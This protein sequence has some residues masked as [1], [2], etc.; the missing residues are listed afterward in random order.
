MSCP[1]QVSC[2]ECRDDAGFTLLE[3][4]VVLAI[5]GLLVGLVAPAAL[6]Q[7]GGARQSVVKQSIARIGTVLDMYKLDTGD[8]P[9]TE[10]GLDA[11]VHR[12][13]SVE[14]WNGPYLKG[15]AV[16]VDPWNHAY[17]YHAPSERE[18]H[19]YDL[20]SHGPNGRGEAGSGMICNP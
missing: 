16:P 19:D 2:A 6:R 5:L 9:S 8:Y 20:C 10:E 15:G 1:R 14:N 12:P 13:S 7:L 17:V 4:L 11:L 3:I 18:G